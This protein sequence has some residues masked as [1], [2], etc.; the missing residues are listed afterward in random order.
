MNWRMY[1]IEIDGYSL[2][3]HRRA[4]SVGMSIH[5]TINEFYGDIVKSGSE[6]FL[7]RFNHKVCSPSTWFKAVSTI[8]NY[9]AKEW[10]GQF[11]PILQEHQL[12]S[13]DTPFIGVAIVFCSKDEEEVREFCKRFENDPRFKGILREF[14]C[15]HHEDMYRAYF[16]FVNLGDMEYDYYLKMKEQFSEYVHP[17]VRDPRPDPLSF[18]PLADKILLTLVFVA[19]ISTIVWCMI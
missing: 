2:P 8:Y 15:Y 18:L 6:Y 14:I 3:Y 5:S 13:K 12:A 1:T 4:E 17:I 10:K 19:S 16:R 9:L 7:D 11:C